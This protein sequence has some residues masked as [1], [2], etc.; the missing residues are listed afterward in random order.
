MPWVTGTC[1]RDHWE[2]RKESSASGLCRNRSYVGDS[3]LGFP[4]ERSSAARRCAYFPFFFGFFLAGFAACFFAG[5]AAGFAA[6]LG[7]GLATGFGG[8]GAAFAALAF[9]GAFASGF[10]GAG[11]GA[12]AALPF[13]P[14]AGGCAAPA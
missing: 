10:A 1:D 14:F 4:A 2:A 6:G 7:A 8:G 9:S 5:F 12:G 13:F 3:R 11:G